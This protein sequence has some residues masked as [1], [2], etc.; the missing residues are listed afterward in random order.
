MCVTVTD[1]VCKKL[2]KFSQFVLLSELF[3][4]IELNLSMHSALTHSQL[5]QVFTYNCLPDWKWNLLNFCRVGS[6]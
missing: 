4:Q 1:T 5:P 2:P 6:L 3:F